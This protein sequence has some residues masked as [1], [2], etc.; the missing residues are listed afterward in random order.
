VRL[1]GRPAETVAACLA[2]GIAARILAWGAFDDI[3]PLSGLYVDEV[4]YGSG[5]I[6]T[7]EGAFDRPPGQFILSGALLPLG[8]GWAR[9]VTSAISLFPAVLLAATAR[10]RWARAAAAA[11]SI[12]PSLVLA[13]LQLLPEAAAAALVSVSLVCFARGSA[14]GSGLAAG[15]ASLF[16]PDLALVALALPIAGAG[17]KA[18]VFSISAILAII[19]VTVVNLASGAGPVIAANGAENLW[20]GSSLELIRVPPGMEFEQLVSM[21]GGGTGDQ[22]LSRWAAAVREDPAGAAVFALRKAAA[23]LELP[24]PGRNIDTGEVYSRTGLLWLTPLTGAALCLAL[25][26][27]LGNR[28]VLRVPEAAGTIC[29]LVSAAVFFPSERYRAAFLP[30]VF[31]LAAAAPPSR[32]ELVRSAGVAAAVLL[33]SFFPI[34]ATRPGLDL[35]IRAGAELDSGSAVEALEDLRGASM[36]G[37]EGADL[38]NLRGIALAGTGNTAAALAEFESGLAIAPGAPTLWRNYAVA[39][40]SAGRQPDARQAAR[41]AIELRPSLEGE[42]SPLLQVEPR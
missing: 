14:A 20:L 1:A 16:R 6:F 36:A 28:R 40:F 13:G 42:L 32:K 7:E 39:L 41:R 25:A 21:D 12:E 30:F 33:C 26:R 35:L 9:R 24:G 11:L 8:I 29:L 38:H 19:P 2:L 31:F 22:F 15:A 5:R 3:L 17:R 23:C 37:F 4:V 10:G 27:I 34:R 18:A